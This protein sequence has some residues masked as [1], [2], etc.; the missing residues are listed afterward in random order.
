[1]AYEATMID[2]QGHQTKVP[3]SESEG[4]VAYEAFQKMK[5]YPAV[6]GLYRQIVMPLLQKMTD[7][8]DHMQEQD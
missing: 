2:A 8:A 7:A 1:M 5:Q 4:K 3:M 6:E